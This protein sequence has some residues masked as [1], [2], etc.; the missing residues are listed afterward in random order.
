MKTLVLLIFAIALIPLASVASTV[1]VEP[2]ITDLGRVRCINDLPGGIPPEKHMVVT[3]KG[4]F[5]IFG[6][7]GD[8]VGDNITLFKGEKNWITLP[9]QGISY[10]II[11]QVA[12]IESCDSI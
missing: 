12:S 7:I 5:T 2:T 11:D 3:D 8:I 10:E 6:F 4:S 9:E 1:N